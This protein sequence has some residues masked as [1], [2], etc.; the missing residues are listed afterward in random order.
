MLLSL[1][2]N[3]WFT[4]VADVALHLMIFMDSDDACREILVSKIFRR[5]SP[6]PQGCKSVNKPGLDNQR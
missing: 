3:Y 5:K 4:T 6:A 2:F 1:T